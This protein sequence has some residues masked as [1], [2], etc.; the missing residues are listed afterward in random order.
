MISP[1]SNGNASSEVRNSVSEM[2][3]GVAIR[4]RRQCAVCRAHASKSWHVVA[5]DQRQAGERRCLVPFDVRTV[6][7]HGSKPVAEDVAKVADQPERR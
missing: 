7:D 5:A 6:G 1:Y 4:F 3:S 2:T